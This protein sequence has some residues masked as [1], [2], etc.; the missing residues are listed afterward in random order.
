MDCCS[1]CPTD[2]CASV[3]SLLHSADD[4]RQQSVQLARPTIDKND[5]FGNPWEG[6]Q[7][8][9][10]L[11]TLT[12]SQDHTGAPNLL[13]VQDTKLADIFRYIFFERKG[14]TGTLEGI[15]NPSA[16]Q[17]KAAFPVHKPDYVALHN[18][19]GKEKQ[20]ASWNAMNAA[21]AVGERP[22][23]PFHA[24]VAQSMQ[25]K[26]SGLGMRPFWCNSQVSP[27]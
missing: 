25:C 21:F 10:R 26:H 4:S 14:S 22:L 23:S 20:I 1:C 6:W 18:P 24:I 11:T 3:S 13:L 16:A 15:P 8:Q 19:P 2:D 27:S 9:I 17:I 12:S 7:V 5:K